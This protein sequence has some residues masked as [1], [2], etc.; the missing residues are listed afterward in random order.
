MSSRIAR[1]FFDLL[2]A[3][4]AEIGDASIADALPTARRRRTVF[5]ANYGRNCYQ[6]KHL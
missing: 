2:P 1:L 3:R 6:T 5:W 4:A